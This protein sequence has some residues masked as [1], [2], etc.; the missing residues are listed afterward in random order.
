MAKGDL[1]HDGRRYQWRW[2][3]ELFEPVP[4]PVDVLPGNHDWSARRTVE[5]AAAAGLVGRPVVDGVGAVDLPGLRL[6][7]VDTALPREHGGAIAHRAD[8]AC[9]A[10][11]DATRDG[12]PAMLVLHH[13][14]ERP[15]RILPWPPGIDGREGEAFLQRAVAANPALFV[16]SGHTHRHRSRRWRSATLTTVGST[17]DYP[18]VWAGYSVHEDG[19]QQVVRRVADPSCLAWTEHTARAVG[20]LWRYLGPGRLTDRCLTA[21]WPV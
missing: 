9:D 17:K 11:A 3:G 7:L 8:E 4:V 5:P 15:T 6:V 13:Q 2:V 12:V 19:I 20:G 10:L 1:T 18:G 21:R 16:T 14:L